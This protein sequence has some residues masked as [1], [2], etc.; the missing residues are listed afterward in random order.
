MAHMG[1]KKNGSHYAKGGYEKLSIMMAKG[2]RPKGS[3][4]MKMAKKAKGKK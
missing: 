2:E 1:E 3:Y 4:K